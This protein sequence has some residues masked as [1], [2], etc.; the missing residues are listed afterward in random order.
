MKIQWFWRES[1]AFW[2]FSS[3]SYW[4][5]GFFVCFLLSLEVRALSTVVLSLFST[6][7]MLKKENCWWTIYGFCSFCTSLDE[8]FLFFSLIPLLEYVVVYIKNWSYFFFTYLAITDE[9]GPWNTACR[10]ILA[11][12]LL[13]RWHLLPTGRRGKIFI[14]QKYVIALRTTGKEYFFSCST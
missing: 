5:W 14:W 3:L 2:W 12:L 8:A 6:V 4:I 7:E 11:P 9:Y 1:N 10:L 13:S